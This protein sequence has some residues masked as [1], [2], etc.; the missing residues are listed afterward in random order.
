MKNLIAKV[1]AIGAVSSSIVMGP[2]KPSH[3][4]DYQALFGMIESACLSGQTFEVDASG[5]AGLVIENNYGVGGEFHY[6]EQEAKGAVAMVSEKL[7]AVQDDKIRECMQGN[8]QRILSAALNDTGASYSTD[9]EPENTTI[10]TAKYLGALPGILDTW[11]FLPADGKSRYFKIDVS[12]PAYV[13]AQV[14]DNANFIY[15]GIISP[16]GKYIEQ[17]DKATKAFLVP[18][19][20]YIGLKPR[21]DDSPTAYKLKIEAQAAE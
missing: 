12:K 13:S 8:V 2:V 11:G 17:D 4:A 14:T 15:V 16:S 1:V 9:A 10:A 6:T 18:G 19:N 20:F 3:A 7:R 5:N 21:H